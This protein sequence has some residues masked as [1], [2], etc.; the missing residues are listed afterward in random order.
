[1]ESRKDLMHDNNV[2]KKLVL[3]R[4]GQSREDAIDNILKL[5]DSPLPDVMKLQAHDVLVGV[6]SASVSFI[7]L[8][9]MS[10]QYQIMLPLPC[11]PGM[12]YA[13]VVLGAGTE[14]TRA[15]SP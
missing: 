5:A 10:G 15:R 2:G 6:R 9:M 8:L 4:Y 13:G 12:E 1:V 14:S 3:T 11:V 7:D